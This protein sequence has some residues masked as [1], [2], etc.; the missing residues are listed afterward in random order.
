MGQRSHKTS[1]EYYQQKLP[2]K[3]HSTTRSQLDRHWHSSPKNES[4]TRPHIEMNTKEDIFRNTGKSNYIQP[5]SR[6][7]TQTLRVISLNIFF[8]VPQKKRVTCMLYMT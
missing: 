3:R 2:R 8:G 6:P 1:G 4:F 5:I 7:W